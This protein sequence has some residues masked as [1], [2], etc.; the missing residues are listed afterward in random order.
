MG[1]PGSVAVETETVLR[2]LEDSLAFIVGLSSLLVRCFPV[3]Q[4]NEEV[5]PLA[6]AVQVIL[7]AP[8]SLPF[9]V[10]LAFSWL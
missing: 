9:Q 1:K 6:V 10:S 5:Q 2:P 7:C 4:Q 3:K 8:R